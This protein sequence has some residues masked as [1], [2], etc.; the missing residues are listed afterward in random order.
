MANMSGMTS[1]ESCIGPT[2]IQMEATEMVGSTSTE[3]DI[4][5]TCLKMERRLREGDGHEGITIVHG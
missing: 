3:G 4:S 2:M 5:N 1:V